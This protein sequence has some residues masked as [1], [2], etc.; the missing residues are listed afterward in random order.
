[1]L[2]GGK[3]VEYFL[4][5]PIN[6]KRF[7]DIMKG[8]RIDFTNLNVSFLV[9]QIFC[10]LDTFTLIHLHVMQEESSKDFQIHYCKIKKERGNCKCDR[11]VLCHNV[12]YCCYVEN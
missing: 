12:L 1:M 11:V 3:L 8:E 6:Q 9:I 2:H 7:H 5:P 10:S 4:R